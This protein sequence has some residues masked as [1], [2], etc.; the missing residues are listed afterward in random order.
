[1]SSLINCGTK[2]NAGGKKKVKQM[3]QC[4][5]VRHKMSFNPKPHAKKKSYEFH[6]TTINVSFS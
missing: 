3:C 5:C 4:E 1:M 6:S 2:E